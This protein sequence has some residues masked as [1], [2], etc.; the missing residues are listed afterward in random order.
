MQNND[1][2][3]NNI[4]NELD[5]RNGQSAEPA[6]PA[7]EERPAPKPTVRKVAP[8]RRTNAAAPSYQQPQQPAYDQYR[9]QPEPAQYVQ[10]DSYG[11]PER[12]MEQAPAR[13]RRK[14]T[15]KDN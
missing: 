2:L 14:K 1:D 10:P 4:L 7:P 11:V 6:A 8:L 15:R 5:N 13:K 3:I 12:G 9:Q